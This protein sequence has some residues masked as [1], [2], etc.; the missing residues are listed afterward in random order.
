MR[1]NE[2]NSKQMAGENVMRRVPPEEYEVKRNYCNL[3]PPKRCASP[4]SH[5]NSN[6][7]AYVN[8]HTKFDYI[9]SYGY[10]SHLL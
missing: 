7:S 6:H 2:E 4:H 5:N 3:S 8:M 9:I 10:P 1:A